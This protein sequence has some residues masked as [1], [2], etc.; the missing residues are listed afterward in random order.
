MI[1]YYVHHQGSGHMRTAMQ[2][3]PHIT[4]RVVVLS[5][6]PKPAR[7]PHNAVYVHLID[8]SA[9]G[10]EQP[11]DS[12]F[13]YTPLAPNVLMRFKQIT[14]AIETYGINRLYVDVSME[15][16]LFCKTLGVNV[17]HNVLLGDRD[18]VPHT[19]LF[20]ACD[21]YASDNDERLDATSKRT[22]PK[23]LHRVGG[24]SRYKKTS[25]QKRVAS[26]IVITT[27]PESDQSSIARLEKTARAFPELTWHV[28]GPDDR[29]YTEPNIVVH[30]IVEDPADLYDLADIIV[31]AGGH[32]TIMEAASFGKRFVCIPEDRPYREQVVAAE[33]LAQNNMAVHCPSF[34]TEN[35]WPD[36]FT[37][38]ERIDLEAFQSI[39]DDAAA[40]R[41]AAIIS[42]LS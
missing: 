30:G 28:I 10:F 18:D 31:G 37:R 11:A 29:T 34:P 22:G 41:L 14:E 13:M 33:V 36:I 1:G 24:I 27:S 32:N 3:I 25:I 5:S 35:E 7:F 12:S 9:D 26:N 19:L 23:K 21:F 17:G 40:Q 4:E 15:V 38:L 39:V 2:V 16:A 42:D 6:F 20:Q 8:D